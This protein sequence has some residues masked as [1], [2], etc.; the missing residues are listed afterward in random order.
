MSRL[1]VELHRCEP[2]DMHI[3]SFDIHCAVF[4]MFCYVFLWFGYM[5]MF[6]QFLMVRIVLGAAR[7]LTLRCL[8]QHCVSLSPSGPT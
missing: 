2:L 8:R 7:S 6:L 1:R 5:Q 3:Y 4:A